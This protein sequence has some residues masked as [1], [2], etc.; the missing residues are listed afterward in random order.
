M[1]VF[2][3]PH[4]WT[5][6]SVSVTIIVPSVREFP[7][8]FVSRAQPLKCQGE[9]LTHS[10]DDGACQSAHRLL[11]RAGSGGSPRRNERPMGDSHCDPGGEDVQPYRAAC[12]RPRCVLP[13]PRGSHRP[14]LPVPAAARAAG[15]GVLRP[16]TRLFGASAGGARAP[17]RLGR[18]AVCKA[19]EP[20][21][22][23][24]GGE[25]GGRGRGST[26]AL[27]VSWR[28]NSGKDR[29]PIRA[30]GSGSRHLGDAAPTLPSGARLGTRVGRCRD[31][32]S[33]GAGWREG[34][35]W[36]TRE[37]VPS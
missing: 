5:C 16:G 7:K 4:T 6:F 15:L 25:R 12:P 9:A 8:P 33:A 23:S 14:R 11:A 31:G 3:P 35:C 1:Y 32:A 30:R 22:G 26:P 27:L 37:P 20:S 13:A 18:G 29:D 34:F 36:G 17:T 24:A 28:I 2:I 19:T 21:A 10:T